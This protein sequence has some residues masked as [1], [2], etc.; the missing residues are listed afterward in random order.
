MFTLIARYT[1]DGTIKEL[2]RMK[3]DF[4]A[5][6]DPTFQLI[7]KDFTDHGYS[8]ELVREPDY[9]YIQDVA[10]GAGGHIQ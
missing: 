1:V 7:I 4:D 2:G 5:Q 6:D 10:G 8:V 3:F 9:D